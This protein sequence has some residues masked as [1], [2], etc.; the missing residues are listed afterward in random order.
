MPM[1]TALRIYM[2][3]IAFILGACLG[4][5]LE[6]AADR[7]VSRQSVFRG[8]SH[9]TACGHT[10]GVLDLIP[11]FGWIF[12]RGKCR[13]CGKRIPASC[14]VTE[15]IG[16]AA[17]LVIVLWCGLSFEAL[18]VAF[19]AP[20]LMLIALID[21]RT[22]EI[23]NGL[24]LYLIALF[25]LSIAAHYGEAL[26]YFLDGLIGAAAVG[27]GLL[28]VSLVTDKILGRESLG[29]G[30]VKL[31]FAVGLFLG[32]WRSLLMLITA[33]I[34][35]I[36]FGLVY[37]RFAHKTTEIAATDNEKPAS[38]DTSSSASSETANDKNIAPPNESEAAETTNGE[39]PFGPAICIATFI[40][41]LFGSSVIN[42]YLSLFM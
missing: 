22:M 16:G 23:P 37:K 38:S 8:R 24:T 30:D 40:C 6:C 28:I 39:F 4:S 35:G 10:L 9:C 21:L 36:V 3:V 13:Y 11:I 19:M 41:M 34:I 15:L 1:D 18:I 25:A 33:C 14:L 7:Y 27:G 26:H 32:L 29:G 12:L 20:A 2:C 42:M 5:F 17:Y 31:L